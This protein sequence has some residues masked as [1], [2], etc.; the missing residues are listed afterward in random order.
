MSDE[1]EWEDA[2]SLEAG[3]HAGPWPAFVDLFAATT[4]VMLVFFVVIA[5]R[6]IGDV[7]IG[8]R[9]DQLERRLKALES[10]G[11]Q[12]EVKREG[13]VVLLILEEQ[14]TFK[15][16]EATL[17]PSA[18][19]TLRRVLSLVRGAEFDTLI[20][21]VE[22]LGHADRRGDPVSNWR[23]SAER[24][25]SVADF[26][27]RS[28]GENPCTIIASGRG[29]YFPRVPGLRVDT[30]PA[31]A[32]ASAY[33]RDRR[34]EIVLHPVVNRDRLVGR[35]GCLRGLPAARAVPPPARP[36]LPRVVPDS[37]TSSSTPARPD[38]A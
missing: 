11:G 12:F 37:A 25:V 9:I 6:Y 20:R 28:L 24:A 1:Q 35:A 30:L 31:P 32:R 17:L 19:P 26:L 4:L 16:G 2:G 10:S 7:S 38:S 29:A 13:A 21:E 22:I 5:F 27:V 8:V 34:V 14:V 33:A 23:L 3:G 36:A 18:H 15:T